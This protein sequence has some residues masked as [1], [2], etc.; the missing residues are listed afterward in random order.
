MKTVVYPEQTERVQKCFE[1]CRYR[2]SPSRIKFSGGRLSELPT[3][4]AFFPFL[5]SLAVFVSIEE[6]FWLCRTD[7][8]VLSA[9]GIDI[10]LSTSGKVGH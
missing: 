6:L 1:N 7:G 8:I 4:S 5:V 3:R 2:L 10:F 9:W